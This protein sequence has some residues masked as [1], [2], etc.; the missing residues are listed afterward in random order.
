M[1][2]NEAIELAISNDPYLVK[3]K[4]PTEAEQQL[5]LKEV[6]YYCPLCGKDLRNRRQA[7]RN[8]LYEIAHIFPNSPTVEQYTRLSV[9][10]RLGN[11]SESFENKIALCKNCHD[12]Q[13]EHTTAEDYLNLLNKKKQF[14]RNT[15]LRDSTLTMGLE[16]VE[17]AEVVKKVCLINEDELTKLNYAPVNLSKKF[18]ANEHL[19]KNKISGYV[20][21]YYPYIRDL[22]KEME[23][24]NGFRIETLSLQI[25]CC[26]TKM[27]AIT[28][29]KNAIFNQLV[30][31]I[32]AK[33][34]SASKE[35]CEA[36]ISFFV[37]NCEVFHE[38]TE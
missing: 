2:K 38:I 24:T 12:Q 32:K 36:V 6:L 1:G 11:N 18:N 16:E 25:K 28:T 37:Q 31:W 5:F 21:A 29:D 34:Q 10:P 22:F 26:F 15:D 27:E 33:T 20:T 14:L 13:D 4:A 7:K 9:L 8:K 23:G 30:D 17:I 3:R 35:A 19:I